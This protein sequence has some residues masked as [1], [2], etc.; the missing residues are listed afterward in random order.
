MRFKLKVHK[1]DSYLI[2]HGY[3]KTHLMIFLNI[4]ACI[5]VADCR[6]QVVVQLYNAMT[7]KFERDG[8]SFTLLDALIAVFI[9]VR[10]MQMATHLI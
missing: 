6:H 4:S 8:H 10:N 1:P 2:K 7:G 9:R 5:V 3:F